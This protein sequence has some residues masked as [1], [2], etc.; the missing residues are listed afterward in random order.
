LTQ[1]QTVWSS[2]RGFRSALCVI[3]KPFVLRNLQHRPFIISVLQPLPWVRVELTRLFC[4]FYEKEGGGGSSSHGRRAAPHRL[5]PAARARYFDGNA[6]TRYGAAV[7][8]TLA[9]PSAVA[10]DANGNPYLAD[11]Q[12][13]VVREVSKAGTIVT[14]AGTGVEGFSGDNGA[15]TLAQLD[16]PTGVAVDTNGNIFIADSHNDRIREVSGGNISTVAGTGAA[17]FGGDGGAATAAMLWLPTAIAVDATGNLYI[18]DTDNQRIRQLGGGVIATVAG[19][20]DQGFVG[21]GGA[22]TG[23]ILNSPRAVAPDAVGNLTIADKL[24]QRLRAANLPTLT[25]TNDGVGIASAA[26]TVTLTN[27]GTA[28]IFVASITFTGA[29]TTT[30]GGSCTATPIAIAAGSS[31]TQNIAFLPVATGAAA[32]SVVFAGTGVVPQDI[33]LAGT[34]VPSTTTVTLTSSNA[35]A[36]AGQAVTFTATVKP[37]ASE[38]RRGPYRSLTG[39]LL[40]AP[41]SRS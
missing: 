2:P 37:R 25:F 4:G 1:K 9:S 41:R 32:G 8:A 16:T 17:S 40:L 11:A 28:A 29:F 33:L 13:H 30:T 21:D 34:S 12:N 15:A 19:T 27:T 35:A 7:A 6:G 10:Y 38:R 14:V 39:P 26:Q 31:C 3:A 23:A 20:G 36:F 5:A 18:A 22:A 24:N